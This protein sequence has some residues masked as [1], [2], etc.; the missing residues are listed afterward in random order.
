M[1]SSFKFFLIG[2]SLII[3]SNTSN[4]QNF[5]ITEKEVKEI[6]CAGKWVLDS[7]GTKTKMLPAKDAMM[8]GLAMVFKTDGTYSI[9]MF[10]DE[11]KGK[12]TISMSD[13]KVKIFE[14][15]PEPES[16]VNSLTK[17]RMVV[18]QPLDEDEFLLLFKLAY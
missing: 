18:A 1:K 4:G 3:F 14:K 6:I 17:G 15:K 8:E 12:W 13:K 11:T 10:D 7:A 5:P 9:N 16:I 2:L